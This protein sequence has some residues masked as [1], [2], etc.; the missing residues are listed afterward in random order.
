MSGPIA[1]AKAGIELAKKK[2]Y[3][4]ISFGLDWIQTD[5]AINSGIKDS[6]QDP[7]IAMLTINLPIWTESYKAA[8]IQARTQARVLLN[9][10]IPPEKSHF[11]KI[12]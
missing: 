7:I 10:K 1:S 9:S 5:D 3:P 6:G 8:E 4:D 12:H 2:F 11:I